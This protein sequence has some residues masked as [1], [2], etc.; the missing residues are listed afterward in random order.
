M[1]ETQHKCPKCGTMMIKLDVGDIN[2]KR[3][4][5]DVVTETCIET[6]ST[7]STVTFTNV[8]TSYS[9]R[10]ITGVVYECPNPECKH[11]ET[12]LT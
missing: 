2:K 8:E 6:L 3:R 1:D 7:S 11:R 4:Q 12:F 5:P 10:R 9:V